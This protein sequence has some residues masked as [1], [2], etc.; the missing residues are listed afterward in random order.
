MT[1]HPE[2]DDHTKGSD[3]AAVFSDQIKGKTST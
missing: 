3:V 1:T 2:Y